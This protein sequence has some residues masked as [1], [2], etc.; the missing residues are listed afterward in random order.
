MKASILRETARR[1]LAQ[2]AKV[3]RDLG[4]HFGKGRVVFCLAEWAR[5][6]FG[7]ETALSK[8]GQCGPQTG[9]VPSGGEEVIDKF[10]EEVVI[11]FH[12][13]LLA[14]GSGA[15]SAEDRAKA[16]A[17]FPTILAVFEAVMNGQGGQE[18]TEVRA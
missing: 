5:R 13:W 2:G 1:L 15:L 11:G 4:L 9:V 3:G 14:V 17:E 8:L 12:R 18:K 10:G 7:A 6:A 16:A